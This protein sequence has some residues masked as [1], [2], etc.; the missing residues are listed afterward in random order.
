LFVSAEDKILQLELDGS[1]IIKKLCS[2]VVADAICANSNSIVYL[3]TNSSFI[4]R[5]QNQIMSILA[6][7]DVSGLKDGAFWEVNFTC[8]NTILATTKG[9]VLV[10]N[11]KF[12]RCISK[13]P[14]HFKGTAVFLYHNKIFTINVGDDF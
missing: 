12:L 14:N 1:N 9:L 3:T 10:G 5:L 11:R 6:G 8:P 13:S 7:D 4:Y 2:N